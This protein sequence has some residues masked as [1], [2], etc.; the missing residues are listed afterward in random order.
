MTKS[1]D[2]LD[3]GTVLKDKYRIETRLGSGGMAVVYRAKNVAVDRMVAI[4]VLNPQLADNETAVQRFKREA[5]AANQARH[6]NIVDVLDVDQDGDL[7]FIVQEYLKGEDLAARLRRESKIPYAEAITI[8]TPVVEAVGAAH[9]KGVVHRD[10]KPDNVFL[11]RMGTKI[12]PKILDFGISKM[13]LTELRATG[14]GGG[15]VQLRGGRITVAG[16]AIGTPYYMS[17]EQIRDPGSVDLRTDVWSIGVMLYEMLSGTMPFDGNDM[18]ELFA[19]IHTQEARRLDKFVPGVP[20]AVAKIVHRCLRVDRE[21]RY[22]SAN[23]LAR[24]LDRAQ[25]DIDDEPSVVEEVVED[26]KDP[27]LAR[28]KVPSNK[29]PAAADPLALE[30]DVPSSSG[31]GRGGPAPSAPSSSPAEPSSPSSSSGGFALELDLPTSSR[32]GAPSAPHSEPSSTVEERVASEAPKK[33]SS[34][35]G[36]DIFDYDDDDDDDAF[37]GMDLAVE[38]PKKSDPR[39]MK[40]RIART[41]TESGPESRRRIHMRQHASRKLAGDYMRL[42]AGGLVVGALAVGSEY[43]TVDGLQAARHA[44]QSSMILVYGG[45]ALGVVVAFLI[46]L[47]LGLRAVSYALF[48][49]SAGLALTAASLGAALVVHGAPGLVPANVV[50]I[51]LFIGPYAAMA[52]IV[53]FVLFAAL[54]GKERREHEDERMLGTLLILCAV[55]GLA[56]GGWVARRPLPQLGRIQAMGSPFAEP[57]RQEVRRFAIDM[58]ARLPPVPPSL[59]LRTTERGGAAVGHVNVQLRNDEDDQ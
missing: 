24:A 22:A 43:L 27:A 48:L 13:P 16:V 31:S 36:G 44:L 51:A 11:V 29:P 38:L 1:H 10:L 45:A 4:K 25:M 12:V 52:A 17:P 50:T 18:G 5:R 53:G 49:A 42:A 46:T 15:P 30:L 59:P 21:A 23:E 54:H 55:L 6:P 39:A 32:S 37:P 7:L 47:T 8:M 14:P 56:A 9:A 20:G 35:L 57:L 40:P 34:S 28:T 2:A 58:R 26:V 41:G 19:R 33:T 3:E